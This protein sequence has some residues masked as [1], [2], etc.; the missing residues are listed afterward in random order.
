[1]DALEHLK[2]DGDE[3]LCR[4]NSRDQS[5]LSSSTLDGLGKKTGKMIL[6]DKENVDIVGGV[7]L[8]KSDFRVLYDNSLE[9]IFERKRQKMRCMAAECIFGKI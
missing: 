5:L 7:I 8:I 6:V 3:F 2:G 4:L 1:M 9:A